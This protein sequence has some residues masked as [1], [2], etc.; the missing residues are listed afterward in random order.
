MTNTISVPIVKMFESLFLNGMLTN[1]NKPNKTEVNI[2]I[3]IA[4]ID[5][6]ENT[7]IIIQYSIFLIYLIS[8]KALPTLLLFYIPR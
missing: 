3:G 6:F 5:Y 2:K 1:K 7:P 8:I 4:N